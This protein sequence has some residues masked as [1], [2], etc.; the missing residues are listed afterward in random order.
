MEVPWSY[1]RAS[2]TP[3][4]RTISSQ[5]FLDRSLSSHRSLIQTIDLEQEVILSIFPVT[6]QYAY[7]HVLCKADPGHRHRSVKRLLD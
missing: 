1:R 6:L 4:M 3:N 2:C 7:R 5:V